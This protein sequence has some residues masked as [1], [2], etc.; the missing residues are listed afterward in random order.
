[1]LDLCQGLLHIS[2][3]LHAYPVLDVGLGNSDRF[4]H[5]SHHLPLGGNILLRHW[6]HVRWWVIQQP[7]NSVSCLPDG[8]E[9]QSADVL[10]YFQDFGRA[11]SP[12]VCPHAELELIEDAELHLEV[13]GKSVIRF[14]HAL[15][16]LGNCGRDCPV[17]LHLRLSLRGD[18]FLT[19]GTSEH[20]LGVGITLGNLNLQL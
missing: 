7:L 1:M 17:H 3:S 18:E 10:E 20:I 5:I 13:A 4:A 2:P 14:D 8:I 9:V 6:T 19:V 11:V 16:R 15:T 12:V